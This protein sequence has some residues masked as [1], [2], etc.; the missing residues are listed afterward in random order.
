MHHHHETGAWLRHALKGNAL[1]LIMDGDVISSLPTAT[2][3]SLGPLPLSVFF[4]GDWRGEWALL[5]CS[6]V[7]VTVVT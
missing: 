1:P 6:G 4:D 2:A 3:L 5:L 7:V